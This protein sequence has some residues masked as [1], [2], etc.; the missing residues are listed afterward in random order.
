MRFSGPVVLALA[1]STGVA[2]PAAAQ[3][4]V[5]SADIQ[6]LQDS[7]YDATRD[8]S[9]IRSRDAATASQLS[10]ELDDARDDV[11]YLKA[12]L[13][14]NEPIAQ[15]EYADVRDRIENIRNRARGDS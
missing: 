14:R 5:T 2:R 1:V 6:R 12:K 3:S 13:R 7:I 10:A 9:Q 11:T 8:V 4:T 15:S